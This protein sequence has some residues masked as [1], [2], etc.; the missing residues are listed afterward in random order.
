MEVHELDRLSVVICA[1]TTDRWAA[2]MSSINAV[3]RQLTVDDELIVVIDHN[4]ELLELATREFASSLKPLIWVVAND[5]RRGLS[6][7]RN[8]GIR[9]ASGQIVAFVDDDATVEP[10]W[11]Q[12]LT[13]HF[14]DPDLAAVGG[15]ADPVWPESRPRWFPP[16][17]DWIVGCS[18]TGLPTTSARVRNLMGCNM[19]FRRRLLVE[20]GGFDTDLGR[21]G[22]H[23]VGCEETELCIRISRHDPAAKITFDP[24]IRVRHH[25]SPDR[26]TVRY[27]LRRSFGEGLSKR[28]I[29]RLVGSGAATRTERSYLTVTVP[30]AMMRYLRD[31]LS[32][33]RRNAVPGGLGRCVALG[34]SVLAAGLGY[35]F[36]TVTEMRNGLREPRSDT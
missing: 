2:L 32:P 36:A 26:T 9:L 20:V 34:A 31:S 35:S 33:G 17:S 10:H 6:G 4:D 22:T 29:S 3:E 14:T 23:P 15:Y 18:Y 5:E 8:C 16:E 13:A 11:R 25:V 28:Q 27:V 12:R 24:D 30:S 1:Y 21:I 19:S 7:A